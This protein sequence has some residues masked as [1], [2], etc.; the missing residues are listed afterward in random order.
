MNLI[1]VSP[2]TAENPDTVKAVPRRKQ[3]PK[4]QSE[5]VTPA[6]RAWT[7]AT[8]VFSTFKNETSKM[9]QRCFEVDWGYAK[10]ERV[11]KDDAELFRVGNRLGEREWSCRCACSSMPWLWCVAHVFVWKSLLC[12]TTGNDDVLL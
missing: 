8:S 3:P 4:P 1:S 6:K 7:L 12:R 2:V 9:K 5:A 11:I 10:V